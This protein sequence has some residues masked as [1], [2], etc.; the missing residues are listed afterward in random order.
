MFAEFRV[1]MKT[2]ND[3]G[4]KKALGGGGLFKWL[5]YK[6]RGA[7]KKNKP[8]LI[9]SVKKINEAISSDQDQVDASKVASSS[10]QS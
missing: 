10:S 2:R 4:G 7:K 6:A 1:A 5:L 8:K 9:T 3:A